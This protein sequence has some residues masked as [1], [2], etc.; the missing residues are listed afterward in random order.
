MTFSQ[1]MHLFFRI[2][3]TSPSWQMGRNHVEH[4]RRPEKGRNRPG[5]SSERRQEQ[6]IFRIPAAYVSDPES[7]AGELQERRRKIF[8]V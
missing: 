1:M 8:P 7:Y 6:G 3:E 2:S 4:R 5:R